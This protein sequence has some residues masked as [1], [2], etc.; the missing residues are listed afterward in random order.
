[1]LFTRVVVFNC[2]RSARDLGR[3]SEAYRVSCVRQLT[4]PT[5][6]YL[7]NT[8]LVAVLGL[9]ASIVGGIHIGKPL[10]KIQPGAN[11]LG[12]FVNVDFQ[13]PEL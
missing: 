13:N 12:V 11:L 5:K 7:A 1:M 4:V 6:K 8:E 10:R 9:R 2:M 3:I